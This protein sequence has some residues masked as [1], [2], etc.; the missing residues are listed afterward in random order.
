MSQL[1][2]MKTL[3]IEDNPGD[4]LLLRNALEADQL[5]VFELTAVETL[6]GGLHQIQQAV[7]DIVLVDLG[8]P[9][10][11]GLQTF[12]RIHQANL[13]LPVVVFSGNEDEQQAIDAVR[14]GAQDYLVKSLSGF[15]MAA[16]TI[17]YAIERHKSQQ[18]LRESETRF[19]SAFFTNP[20]SQ[21]IISSTTGKIVEANDACC[22][23]CEY[24]S[25]ELIGTDPGTL[26][27]WANPADQ[28]DVLEELQRTGRLLPREIT[29]RPNSGKIRTILFSVEQI[30]WKGEACLISSSVDITERKRAEENLRLSELALRAAQSVAR[31][32]SW[33]WDLKSREVIWS[34]E[35]FNIFGIDKNSYTGRLGDVIARVIH[36]DDLH[37]VLPTNA[38]IIANEPVEYRIILPDT[39][40]RHIWAKSGET[41][42]DNE[43]KPTFLTGIAQ[44]ITERKR[45]EEERL[46][47]NERLGLAT[48]AA[49]LGIWDWDIQKN[50]LVW[51]DQ[52]YVLYGIKPGDFGGAYEAWLN[53]VHPHDRELANQAVQQVVHGEKEYDAEFRVMWLDGSVHWLKATGQVFRD[54]AGKPMRMVGVNY[55]ITTRKQAEKRVQLQVQRLRALSAID[56]VIS[57]SPDM[58]S[59]LEALLD[60]TLVQLGV[61]AAT[62]LLLDP[63]TQILEYFA[64]KG[65]RTTDIR[66]SSLQLG[67]GLAGQVGLDL[68]VLHITDLNTIGDKFVRRK[69]LE[70]DEFVEYFGVPLI[71]KDTLKG[72]LEIFN[73]TPL[74]PDQD[75]LNY[76]DT[77][78]GQAAIAVDNAQLFE[79]LHRS[80]AE[81]EQRVKLRTSD[82]LRVNAELEHA[83]RTKDEFLANMSHELR[84]PLTGILGFTESMQ[85]SSYGQPNE[86]QIKALQNIEASGRHLLALIND[87]LDLSKIEA[88]RFDIYPELISVEAACRASLMFVKGQAQK[89]SL[90]LEYQLE[91]NVRSVFAD[92]RRLKQILVNLLSNAVKF[93]PE[94]GKVTLAVRNDPEKGQID[95]SVADTGIGI[96][97][98]DLDHLF[99]PFTQVD[100][101]LNRKYEGTG[102]GLVLVLR[103]A[104]MHGGNVQVE[105]ELGRGSCFTVSLPWQSQVSTPM[106][107]QQTYIEEPAEPAPNSQ[108]V[109]LLAEDS[110]SNIEAIGD[111][112]QFRGYT[113]VIAS[114]GV[115]ALIKAEESNPNLILMDIQM[116]V[117]DGL[118]TMRRLRADPRFTATP[119]I[120][121]TALAMTGDRER[122]IEA[123]ATDYLS[124]PVSLKELL[125][126]I[127]RLIQP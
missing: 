17:R 112:L 108:G 121:L 70:A 39:S 65:F 100:S 43:G 97:K 122:C 72:V 10:S 55:D 23:L 120:A 2:S 79:E 1:P 4:V 13:T 99:S 102:L 30:T 28:L 74:Y 5:S 115:E 90:Q 44:D 25:E 36:P 7:F 76:L 20:L 106:D 98:E 22:R 109:I 29:I 46:K 87:I 93:T 118:E 62:I 94:K 3:L 24:S 68:K 31:I 14:N 35:M 88:G 116:P 60:E 107:T 101:S 52:M 124:K 113:L 61:D 123:G 27:L 63:T 114:N 104:E 21:S 110:S 105:T 49:Q 89:K 34:D 91:K 71:I 111:Y 59:S 48:H 126:K 125:D 37:I 51:D 42:L 32:G 50:E 85:L 95:F 9:D 80:N 58:R 117:M 69:L 41:I 67:E 92:P 78:G 57:T 96:A 73:R 56:R 77:L 86:K 82:L 33:K 26:D 11:A 12:E 8:L 53:G 6:A 45:T 40:I 19:S 15:E 66:Q 16:R 83:N 38:A 119:I 84:T 18:A 64:G 103:L 47:L 54:E 75:W 81:L 127:E